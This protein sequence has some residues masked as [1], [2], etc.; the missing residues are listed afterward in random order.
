[1]TKWLTQQFWHLFMTYRAFYVTL[2]SPAAS[3]AL[4]PSCGLRLYC[5]FVLDLY[6]S[7]HSPVLS[8]R[9][10]SEKWG[11]GLLL[12]HLFYGGSKGVW[13]GPFET[14][15]AKTACKTAPECVRSCIGHTSRTH[16]RDTQW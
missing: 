14:G 13:L 10:R 7:P 16:I 8:R 15:M 6:H 11:L 2:L 9:S 12:P 1:M 4:A 5:M 3:H